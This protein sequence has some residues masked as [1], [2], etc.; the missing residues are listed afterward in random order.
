M[1]VKSEC[2]RQGERENCIVILVILVGGNM[3]DMKVKLCE[4]W[5][6]KGDRKTEL[7]DCDGGK[8]DEK[9]GNKRGM[10]E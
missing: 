5:A 7:R 1:T 8:I 9:R 4:I 3:I 2:G 10:R 6:G